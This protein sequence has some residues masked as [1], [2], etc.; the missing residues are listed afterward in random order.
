MKAERFLLETL[1]HFVRSAEGPPPGVPARV[2]SDFET[3]LASICAEQG[4]SPIVSRSLDRLALP[5]SISSVTAARLSSHAEA[6]ESE[7]ARRLRMLY[8]LIELLGAGGVSALAMGDGLAATRYPRPTLRPLPVLDILVHERDLARALAMLERAG[9]RYPGPHP[10]FGRFRTSGRISE[11]RA[12]ELVAY[13]HH[14]APLFVTNADDVTVRVRMRSVD[15]GRAPARE[16]AWNHRREV[17]LPDGRVSAVSVEDHLIERAARAGMAGMAD[18]CAL[19]DVGLVLAGGVRR[20]DRDY[21]EWRARSLGIATAVGTVMSEV[22][23][24]FW[25]GDVSRDIARP[26]PFS[27]A[28]LRRW[29][30]SDRIDYGDVVSP[31]AGRFRFGLVAC[32]GPIAKVRWVWHY[33][34]PRRRWVRNLVGGRPNPWRWLKFL[35][36]ARDFPVHAGMPALPEVSREGTVIPFGAK[37]EKRR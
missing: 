28:V 25:L 29:W 4:L 26:R 22:D 33:F 12:A 37:P 8:E 30:R 20:L 32:G 6:V 5:P 13:H 35:L 3:R 15:L 14:I 18:L 27:V 31:R 21:I 2:R 11:R 34:V 23:A 16:P 9:Y 17:T 10:V 1:A 19:V 7:T 24:M 36:L